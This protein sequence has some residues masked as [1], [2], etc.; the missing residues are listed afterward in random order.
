MDLQ[1]AVFMM[2]ALA[3]DAVKTAREILLAQCVNGAVTTSSA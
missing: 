2:R 3:L 1:T